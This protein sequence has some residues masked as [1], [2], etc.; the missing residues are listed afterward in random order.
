LALGIQ[1]ASRD[2]MSQLDLEA[3]G[4]DG[5]DNYCIGKCF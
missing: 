3:V 1:L 5:I 2:G 4:E